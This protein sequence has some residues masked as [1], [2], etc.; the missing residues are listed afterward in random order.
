MSKINTINIGIAII[1]IGAIAGLI[2]IFWDKI[3]KPA[4]ISNNIIPDNSTI[5]NNSNSDTELEEPNLSDE[6]DMIFT[7]STITIRPGVN[8]NLVVGIKAPRPLP[9]ALSGATAVKLTNMD[10]FSGEYPLI[11]KWLD[12]DGNVGAIYVNSD[13]ATEFVGVSTEYLNRGKIEFL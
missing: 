8:G 9:N 10:M 12:D 1:V 5:T 11:Y 13:A 6:S 7:V 4:L 3:Y 2:S